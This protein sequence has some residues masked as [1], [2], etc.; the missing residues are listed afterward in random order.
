MLVSRPGL[1]TTAAQR[2]LALTIAG[3][4]ER[5]YVTNAYFVPSAPLR[6]MLIDAAQGGVD[7]RI[8]LPG[9]RNDHAST[10]WAGRMYFDELLEGGVRI[11]EYQ[12]A[13]LHAKALVADGVWSTVG[14]LNLDRRSMRLNEEWSLLVQDEGFGAAMDSIFLADL[15][16]S[17]ELTLEVHRARPFRERL[18]EFVVSLVVPLL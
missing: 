17:R 5:L 13:M 15:Q 6:K 9:P 7:V 4:R 2:F 10:K 11:W 12:P 14:S 16:R 8:L 3:A 18:R 1:G